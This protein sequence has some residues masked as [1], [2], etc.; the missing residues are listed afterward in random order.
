MNIIQNKKY[1]FEPSELGQS[2]SGGAA[3]WK[4]A[5]FPPG[6]NTAIQVIQIT[7]YFELEG[8]HK[9]HQIQLF[10]EQPIQGLNLQPW[11][12]KYHA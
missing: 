7:E 5:H 10:S 11:L 6:F 1:A 12:Y 8:A 9:D 4:C 3:S 2:S